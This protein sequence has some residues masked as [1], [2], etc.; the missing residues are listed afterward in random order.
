[1]T[2]KRPATVLLCLAPRDFMDNLVQPVGRTNPY[3]VLAHGLIRSDYAGRSLSLADR[4]DGVICEIFDFYRVRA[5]YRAFLVAFVCRVL[6]RSVDLFAAS[7]CKS[8]VLN[9]VGTAPIYRPVVQHQDPDGCWNGTDMA[10]YLSRYKPFNEER[11]RIEAS[12]LHKIVDLCR[13]ECISCIVVNMPLPRANTALIDPQ[14]YSEYQR[15][16]QSIQ[17]PAVRYSDWIS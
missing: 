13:N 17:G 8:A 15:L 3:Q 14:A 2:G 5:Q 4:V 16:L 12:Y 7:S 10:D 1:M 9:P 6:N 11:F